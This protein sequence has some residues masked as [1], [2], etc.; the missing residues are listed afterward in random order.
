MG[1]SI[2]ANI[3]PGGTRHIHEDRLNS[4]V[5]ET[6]DAGTVLHAL[7]YDP[8]GKTRNESGTSGLELTFTGHLRDIDTGLYYM[9]AR[10]Y[11][12]ELGIFLSEDPQSYNPADPFTYSEYVYANLNPLTYIDPFGWA[13]CD[14]DKPG[15]EDGKIVDFDAFLENYPVGD[16]AL[17]E[18]QGEEAEDNGG[19]FSAVR[20]KLN[21]LKNRY[22][23]KFEELYDDYVERSPEGK[24][25]RIAESQR[26]MGEIQESGGIAGDLIATTCEALGP[27]D[28]EEADAIRR[29]SS[30][31]I[32][33]ENIEEAYSDTG[34]ILEAG[35]KGVVFSLIGKFV[36]G[37]KAKKAGRLAELG[38]IRQAYDDEVKALGGLGDS[39]RAAGE[40]VE[41][42]ARTLHSLRREIGKKYKSATPLGTRL[43]IY[44]RNILPKR[45]GGQGYDSIYG[46]SIG[47]LRKHGKTWE[48]IIETAARPNR[49]ISAALGVK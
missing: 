8:H 5:A 39:M 41:Q 15:C 7:T 46:P 6:G 29:Q 45:L 17:K 23:A 48:E 49:K 1:R 25:K 14:P 47:W 10:W 27:C 36:A 19:I 31:P 43:K 37:R 2:L 4:V 3:T 30:K 28:E 13:G 34:E 40:G 35:G 18:Q 20:T 9:K 12:P 33:R 22:K 26:K 42:V 32:T 24:Q 16:P 21:G 38:K 11:D 44:A